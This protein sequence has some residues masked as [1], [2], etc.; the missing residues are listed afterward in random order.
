VASASITT[1]TL[2]R[3]IPT[4]H[5]N[6]AHHRHTPPSHFN[7]TLCHSTPPSNSTII[8]LA[9]N[10]NH[11]AYTTDYLVFMR[12]HYHHHASS[13]SRIIAVRLSGKLQ[14]EL[15]ELV[16]GGRPCLSFFL[17]WRTK[18]TPYSLI[19]HCFAG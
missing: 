9:V 2:R 12:E 16:C 11:S 10:I 8:K 1:V 7:V 15:R 19:A 3:R 14:R 18:C 4:S 6:V 5:S 13:S 17:K